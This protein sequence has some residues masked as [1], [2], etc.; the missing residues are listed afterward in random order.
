MDIK[1]PK[2]IFGQRQIGYRIIS[3]GQAGM[4]DD[5]EKYWLTEHKEHE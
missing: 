2:N 5:I 3:D 4:A 1:V